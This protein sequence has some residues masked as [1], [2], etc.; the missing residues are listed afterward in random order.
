M[1]ATTL[2]TFVKVRFP[3]SLPH[4]FRGLKLGGLAGLLGCILCEFVG[5]DAGLGYLIVMA[6]LNADVKLLF[7]VLIAM[8]ILGKAIYSLTILVEKYSISWHVIMRAEE[9]K[10]FT[11]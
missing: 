7:S 2:Q 1:S 11:A 8:V 6:S 5:S 4:F 10:F 9:E 3:S